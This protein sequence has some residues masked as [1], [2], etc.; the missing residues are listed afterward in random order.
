VNRLPKEKNKTLYCFA[1]GRPPPKIT[2]KKN[3]QEI[4]N[5][6]NSFEIP[7]AFYGRLLK[8]INVKRDLHQD[9]YTCEAE[10]SQN[11]G[12]PL[13]YTINL[14]VE[15]P[16]RWKADIPP[17]KK[18]SIDIQGKGTLLCNAVADPVPS[19]SWYKDGT[20]IV[21]S[22]SYVKVA[23]DTLKFENVTLQEDG[24]Y[25]CVA[26]NRLGMIVSSTWVNVRGN[27]SI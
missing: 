23:N 13:V 7:D 8:I 21:S 26:E 17:P 18:K 25:Q 10:N 6:W 5:G 2:W 22:T 4:I 11:S 20:R 24:V 27:Y 12:N 3:G 14:N 15:V 16:P 1:V 19:Y 9:V